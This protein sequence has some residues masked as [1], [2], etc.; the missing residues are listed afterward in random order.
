MK[1][2][3][4]QKNSQ[5]IQILAVAGK[6]ERLVGMIFTPSSS[7]HNVKDAIQVCGFT[8]A[9]DLWGCGIFADK[10]VQVKDIQLRFT[11]TTEPHVLD[12]IVE[13]DGTGFELR[14]QMPCIRCYNHPCTCEVK[15]PGKN[16]YVAKRSWK[17]SYKPGIQKRVG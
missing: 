7:G 15:T 12:R 13:R 3:F 17:G 4:R 10:G 14:T 11:P 5:E 6:T 16:P 9:L 8:E 2:K 1:L